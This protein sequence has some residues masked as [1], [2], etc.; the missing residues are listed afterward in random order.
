MTG[1]IDRADGLG[2]AIDKGKKNEKIRKVGQV[3]GPIVGNLAALCG[4][5]FR[6]WQ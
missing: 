3:P 2:T 6:K 5:L 4:N 1:Y